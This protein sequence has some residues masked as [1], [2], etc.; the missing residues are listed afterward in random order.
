MNKTIIITGAGGFIGACLVNHFLSSGWKVKALVHRLPTTSLPHVEY[1][2]YNMMQ[3]PDESI[4]QEVDALVHCAYV[5]FEKNKNADE[6][7]FNGTKT[8]IGQCRKWRIKMIFLS[9]LS[10]HKNALSHYGRSKLQC[11]QLFDLGQEVVLNTGLVIGKNGLFG[12]MLNRMN[13]SRFFPLLDGGKQ[14]VQS[15][16]MEDIFTI[17]DVIL[18]RNLSGKYCIAESKPITLKEFYSEL[19]NQLHKKIT[20]VSIPLQWMYVVCKLLE[21]LHIPFPVTTDNLLGLKQMTTFETKEDL[22]KLGITIK[23]YKE[24]FQSLLK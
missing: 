1:I 13:H 21:K 10:A 24:S 8:L 15:I 9:S 20:F 6:I 22:S 4:F 23:N 2:A 12:E 16:F 3:T 11:E 7:N 19:A 17:L 5:R 14:K 18:T